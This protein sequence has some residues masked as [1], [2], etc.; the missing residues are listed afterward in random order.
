MMRFNLPHIVFVIL[1]CLCGSSQGQAAWSGIIDPSRA[2]DWSQAGATIS[3]SRTQC[4][5]SAC[6][7][8]S[9]G[10]T[11]TAAS[12][13][14]A[15]ASAP[16]NTFVLIPAGT[17][18]MSTGIMFPMGGN[19]SS[20]CSS[21][22]SNITLRG[23]GSNSTF[24]TFASSAGGSGNCGGDDICAAPTDINYS[25]GPSNTASWS[26]TNRANVH[27]GGNLHH[28]EQHQQSF[29]RQPVDPRSDR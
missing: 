21:N 11:V 15:L 14:A 3:T 28:F 16:A 8:V 17:Y 19:M 22:C 27:R 26:G 13:N 6:T 20:N 24:L 1:L 9:N 29:R 12:I 2:I 7:T 10:T 18:S 4:V 23:S 25:G 5:T